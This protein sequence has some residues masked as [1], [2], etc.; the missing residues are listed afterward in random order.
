MSEILGFP[1]TVSMLTSVVLALREFGI[2]NCGI[3]NRRVFSAIQEASQVILIYGSATL[4][5]LPLRFCAN[6]PFGLGCCLSP[7]LHTGETAA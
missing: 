1:A 4:R 2:S 6:I 5:G 3:S 7:E